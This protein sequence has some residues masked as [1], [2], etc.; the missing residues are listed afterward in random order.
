MLELT[1]Q[2]EIVT[3]AA[4]IRR[5][6][7]L[8]VRMNSC[9]CFLKTENDANDGHIAAGTARQLCEKSNQRITVC[10]VR[11]EPRCATSLMNASPSVR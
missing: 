8:V 2:R 1:L 7:G 9:F 4:N 5:S 6:R 11:S 10:C 3:L